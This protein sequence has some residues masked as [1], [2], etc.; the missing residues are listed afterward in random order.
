MIAS[1]VQHIDE[2][3]PV[4]AIGG[5]LLVG[6]IAIVC[7]TLSSIMQTRAKEQSRR[8]IAAYVAEGSMT[9]EDAQ[10]L[11]AESPKSCG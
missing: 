4:I 1:I 8:E 2:L 11:M 5:G 7:S 10:R 6:G 9:P 3:I